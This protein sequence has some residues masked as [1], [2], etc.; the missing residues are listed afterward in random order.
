MTLAVAKVF[1][2]KMTWDEYFDK[3]GPDPDFILDR[4]DNGPPQDRD[5]F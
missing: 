4:S 2:P 5:L 1:K 3:Y